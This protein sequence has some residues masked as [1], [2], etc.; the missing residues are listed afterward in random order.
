MQQI[1][2]RLMTGLIPPVACRQ[3]GVVLLL[4]S[5][6]THDQVGHSH[7]LRRAWLLVFQLTEP[8][9][10]TYLCICRSTLCL[11][12]ACGVIFISSWSRRSPL[13]QNTSLHKQ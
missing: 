8:T 7:L 6:E 13:L 9:G 11:R 5:F 1:E 2:T 10:H 12:R 4:A 3:D